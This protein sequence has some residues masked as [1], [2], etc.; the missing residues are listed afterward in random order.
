MKTIATVIAS[1]LL[2]LS[3][4]AS[5]A[6]AEDVAVPPT[7]CDQ[8]VQEWRTLA[9]SYYDMLEVEKGQVVVANKT[10]GRLVERVNRKQDKIADL[11]KTIRELRR[12][13]R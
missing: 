2:S 13:A 5:P 8:S 1:L 6:S 10:I 7:S 9:S 3:V 12:D 4:L 11:Y